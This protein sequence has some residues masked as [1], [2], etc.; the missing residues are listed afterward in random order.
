MALWLSTVLLTGML[1]L[2]VACLVFLLTTSS[3]FPAL[4][5]RTER[6]PRLGLSVSELP[7][8]QIVPLTTRRKRRRRQSLLHLRHVLQ[9]KSFLFGFDLALVRFEHV[10]CAAH[11]SD[12]LLSVRLQTSVR[13]LDLAIVR[14]VSGLICSLEHVRALVRLL[15][16]RALIVLRDLYAGFGHAE[17][18]LLGRQA[19][20][21]AM[22]TVRAALLRVARYL[23]P[24]LSLEDHLHKAVAVDDGSRLRE[25]LLVRRGLTGRLDANVEVA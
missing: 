8:R 5:L 9:R 24:I 14:Q 18:S 21:R 4:S 6:V 16:E 2:H 25:V 7:C 22:R 3:T 20:L 1:R 15:H 17:T 12:Y 11:F 10:E 23:L 19:T 13:A